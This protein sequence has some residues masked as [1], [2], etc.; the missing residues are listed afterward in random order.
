MRNTV[1]AFCFAAKDPTFSPS[2]PTSSRHSSNYETRNS[3]RLRASVGASTKHIALDQTGSPYIINPD[4]KNII[5]E[6]VD[7]T[8]HFLQNE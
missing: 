7:D 8:Q 4:S 6:Q 3:S 2:T 1:H 5:T